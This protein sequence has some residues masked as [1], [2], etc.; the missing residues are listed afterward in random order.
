MT[1]IAQE[2]LK[3]FE[4]SWVTLQWTVMTDAQRNTY[5]RQYLGLQVAEAK[6]KAA[7]KLEAEQQAIADAEQRKQ[8]VI[9]YLQSLGYM[10]DNSQEDWR[11]LYARPEIFGELW[12]DKADYQQSISPD[13]D[14]FISKAMEIWDELAK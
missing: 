14:Y 12:Q 10:C 7:N 8:A 6:E 9:E 5:L 4:D 2:A 3:A 13:V 11:K 1:T